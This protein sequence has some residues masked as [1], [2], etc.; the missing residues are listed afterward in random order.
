VTKAK[1]VILAKP[2]HKAPRETEV[3]EET[4]AKTVLIMC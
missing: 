4:R 3:N 2:D 1:L